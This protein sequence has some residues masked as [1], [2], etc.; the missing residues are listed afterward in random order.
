M[1]EMNKKICIV[2]ASARAACWSAVRAGLEPCAF[3]YFQDLDFPTGCDVRLIS[4]DEDASFPQSPSRQHIPC[5]PVGGWENEPE[6]MQQLES[7]FLLWNTS[8][9]MTKRSRDPSLIQQ[10]LREHNLPNLQVRKPSDDL[11]KEQWIRKPL[12]GTGGIGISRV[13]DTAVESDQL[14]YDQQFI[15]GE[16]YSAIF[17]ATRSGKMNLLGISSQLIGSDELP[18]RPF[19]YIGSIGPV[20]SGGDKQARAMQATLKDMANALSTQI[21]FYGLV[22]FDFI[23]SHGDPYLTEINPRYCASIEVLELALQE[24]FLSYFN[25]EKINTKEID[26]ES[27]EIESDTQPQKVGKAI[28]YAPRDFQLPENWDW[29]WFAIQQKKKTWEYSQWVVPTVSDLPAAGTSFTTDDPICT[30]WT[31]QVSEQQ[32][33]LELR[34]LKERLKESLNL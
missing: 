32:C 28:L 10:I 15:S 8:P 22:G 33:R 4:K 29:N 11:N 21:K 19:A 2:G 1:P 31:Q 30:V 25:T 16:S 5:L 17:F 23:V 34:K 18:Q 7:Q 14:E 27:V 26:P 20:F 9:A 13:A 3:D 6:T 12:L 24:S